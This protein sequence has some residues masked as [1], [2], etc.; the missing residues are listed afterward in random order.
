MISE[1]WHIIL[2][3]GSGSQFMS[4]E[5]PMRNWGKKLGLGEYL[6]YFSMNTI[7]ARTYPG[8]PEILPYF[9][10]F[11]TGVWTLILISL[12]FISMLT[13]LSKG[14]CNYRTFG[15]NLWNYSV[16]LIAPLHKMPKGLNLFIWFI[17]ALFLTKY[18]LVYFFDFM[19]RSVPMVTINT[20]QDLSQRPD[21][22]ILVRG[23]SSLYET[24]M[25]DNSEMS[26]TLYNQLELFTN[27][28]S[29]D[30]GERLATG[31]NNGSVAF[32][33]DHMIMISYLMKVM[34]DFKV[35]FDS[36]HISQ[37]MV[38]F[39]PYFVFFNQEMPQWAHT[40]LKTM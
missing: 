23:D 24:I 8:T 32:V 21:M 31:L 11:S 30:I 18:F 34:Q 15:Q 33:H 40:C 22:K 25:S 28:L 16:I 6:G 37:A 19:I 35:K 26:N 5:R 9:K 20:F 4:Y 29:E 13:T 27:L 7:A 36:I 38:T 12:A 14:K 1:D 2:G 39:E 3:P 10:C 17:S